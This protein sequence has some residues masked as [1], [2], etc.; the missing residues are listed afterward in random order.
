MFQFRRFPTYAY[1]IQRRLTE[2]CSDGFPH[3]DISGSTVICTSPKLIAACHVL[4][5]LLMPRHSPCALLRLTLLSCE[6]ESKQ[7]KLSWTTTLRQCLLLPLLSYSPLYKERS[8]SGSQAFELCRLRVLRNC[9]CYPFRKVPQIIFVSL[10]CLL[11]I[12]GYFV[13]FS[14]CV[15]SFFR[16]QIQTLNS[17]NACIQSRTISLG[18][19]PDGTRGVP[20]TSVLAK[21]KPCRRGNSFAPRMSYP[22]WG[23]P[24]DGNQM[25]WWA[26]VDSNHRPHDYQ[27]C[28]LAS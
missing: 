23:S 22:L 8:R 24:F 10:C 19:V 27:S 5:R 4:H 1:L 18:P 16:N 25:G 9:L 11:F 13:Q 7:R 26:Q 28:A 2:Y 17:L 20:R 12:L 14:R 6:Q 21:P 3:S 15:S